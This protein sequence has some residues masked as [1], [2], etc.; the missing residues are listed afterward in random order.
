MGKACLI[1]LTRHVA[2]ACAAGYDVYEYVNV[3]YT[4]AT[5]SGGLCMKL[6]QT[7]TFNFRVYPARP[8]S[9]SLSSE[10]AV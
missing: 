10:G 4:S 3:C 7:A 2:G 1:V 8:H 5:H 6:R 9:L